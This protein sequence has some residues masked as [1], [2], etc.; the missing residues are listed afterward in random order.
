MTKRPGPKRPTWTHL[1]EE[2]LRTADDFITMPL[3]AQ[4]VGG[5]HS[6][7]GAALHHLQKYHVIDCVTSPE[8]LHWFYRGE[9]TR[10]LVHEERVL[11]DKPR[12]ARIRRFS[13]KDG[14]ERTFIFKDPS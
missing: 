4:A 5:T 13:C 9:D 6:Q 8:G 2:V 10:V 3:L 12:K 7:V 14:V 1:V 11:E